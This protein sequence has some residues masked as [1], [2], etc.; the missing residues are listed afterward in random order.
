MLESRMLPQEA[1][2][3]KIPQMNDRENTWLFFYASLVKSNTSWPTLKTKE[4]CRAIED[5]WR[6][7]VEESPLQPGVNTCV[8]PVQCLCEH[9]EEEDAEGCRRSIIKEFHDCR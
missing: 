3:A 8:G 6:V 9:P 1:L 5:E 7:Q 2:S 4:A